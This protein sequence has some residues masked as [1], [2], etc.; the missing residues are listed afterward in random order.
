MREAGHDVV[1][2][3]EVASAISDDDVCR[4]SHDQDRIIITMDKDFGDLVMRFR[5]KVPGVILLRLHG[6][7]PEEMVALVIAA[8]GQSHEWWGYF[9][10]IHGDAIRMRPLPPPR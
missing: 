3:N 6:K 2:V 1:W 10:V 8:L 9:S 7:R 4:M 5:K